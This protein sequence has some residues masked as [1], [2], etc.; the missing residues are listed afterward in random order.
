MRYLNDTMEY[1]HQERQWRSELETVKQGFE[2]RI[3]A[4]EAPPRAI[5]N[6]SAS[7]N[8]LLNSHPEWSKA[9]WENASILASSV[10]DD[11]RTA[12]NWFYQTKLDSGQNLGS[13]SALIADGH[14]SFSSSG[15]TPIWDRI[16]GQVAIGHETTN[17]DIST[18]LSR[19]F[20]FPGQ[21]YYVYFETI[22]TDIDADLNEVE[23]YCGFW[24]NTGSEL[25]WIEGS[26]F[27]P[28]ATVFGAGGTRTL[29]YK[30]LASTDSGD[31]ILST[32][33]VVNN[34]PNSLSETN[35]VRLFFIG[36]PG[37]ISFKVYRFDG[38]KHRL[39]GEVNNSIDLQFFDLQ[40]EIG[41]LTTGFPAITTQRPKAYKTTV[42]L[43]ATPDYYTAHTL[44][45]QIPTTY[46]RGLTTNNKQYFRWG[47]T[48]PLNKK[49]GLG[50]RRMMVSEG[51]GPWVRAQG[52]LTIPLSSPSTTA[53]YSPGPGVVIGD[54]PVDGAYCVTLDTI[55]E[56]ITKVN[57][58][59]I[60]LQKPIKDIEVGMKLVC[61][62][63]ISPITAI[64]D[65]VVQQTYQVITESGLS[66]TCSA[67]HRLLRSRFDKAGTAVYTLKIGDY[68]LVSKEGK[69]EQ[70]PIKDIIV[71]IG[72]T[73][74][75]TVSLPAPHLFITNGIVSHNTKAP[76]DPNAV[77]DFLPIYTGP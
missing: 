54:G 46:D 74:V 39:V 45:I 9:A 64:K 32:D 20:V 50:I 55:V 44:L 38:V 18:P 5:A 19:D 7:P 59:D 30:V 24:D 48:G 66:V 12:Y 29:T 53:A 49:R 76:I 69:F 57:G 71:K 8:Y 13:S 2:E 61:G 52:D 72:D 31:Q 15:E 36:A 43:T 63:E 75:R 4:L 16:N 51:F 68:I 60:V 37:F 56:V 62:T 25:K 23:L 17:Y 6:L 11:N 22:L 40:E 65:G 10:T 3:A 67:N 27:T 34:A 26:D 33:I 70:E 47:I 58:F 77:S 73:Q 14:S 28:T 1:A 21:R 42:S 41:S 35:H